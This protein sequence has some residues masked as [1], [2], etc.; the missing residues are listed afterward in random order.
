MLQLH[1]QQVVQIFGAE[2]G[3]ITLDP[4]EFPKKGKNSVGVAH[5][6]CGNTGKNDNCQ[7]GVFIGYVSEKGYGLIDTQLYMPE[8]W[9]DEDHKE[10]RKTNLVPEDL[11]FQTKNDIAS[12]LIKSVS[13]K[14]PAR[15]IGCDASFG[16]D[17]DFLKSLPNSTLL[18]CRY[19]IQ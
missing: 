10:L 2:D 7:S 18:F 4:S 3:M 11:S 1:Q 14:F 15:W 13:K 17:M 12:D 9:F 5:Q 6:Y 8:S 16:S 19:Q